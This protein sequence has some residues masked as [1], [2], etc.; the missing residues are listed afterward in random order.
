[1]FQRRPSWAQLTKGGV[2]PL[3]VL[4]PLTG[5]FTPP[6]V[7][8]DYPAPDLN[9]KF[10]VTRARQMYEQRRIGTQA[11]LERALAKFPKQEPAKPGKERRHGQSGKNSR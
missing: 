3:V 5:G 7:G 6:T 8:D 4:R 11:E 2:P 9:D 1:M 10:Q